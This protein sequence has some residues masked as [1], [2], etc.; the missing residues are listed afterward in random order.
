ML[1]GTK[2]SH[3]D[4]PND[5]EIH[6]RSRYS[7][8]EHVHRRFLPRPTR[9]SYT[10]HVPPIV[11]IHANIRSTLWWA[12]KWVVFFSSSR[13]VHDYLWITTAI[14]VHKMVNCIATRRSTVVCCAS[15][16]PKTRIVKPEWT[17]QT[18]HGRIKTLVLRFFE[19]SPR[20]AYFV[21]LS[22]RSSAVRAHELCTPVGHL[23]S[24]S[25]DQ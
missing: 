20:R 1:S 21:A 8:F 19:Q 22:R 5:D 7:D 12:F 23:S 2:C 16:C 13:V 14:A 9:E 25:F 4:A 17:T 10:L 3:T 15:E 11:S 18:P 6:N 24:S